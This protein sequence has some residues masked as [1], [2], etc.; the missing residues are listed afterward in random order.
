M[1]TPF[2]KPTFA[3][4][5]KPPS[6]PNEN[7]VNTQIKAKKIKELINLINQLQNLIKTLKSTIPNRKKTT[8]NKPNHTPTTTTK[9]MKHQL[10]KV[11]TDQLQKQR[12][13]IKNQ[14]KTPVWKL[15]QIQKYRANG[16]GLNIYN[17]G[18]NNK[19]HGIQNNIVK[20][21]K[22]QPNQIYNKTDHTH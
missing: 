18:Y 8:I 14:L 13:K 10:R 11:D 9:K 7:Q 5:I 12:K 2:I 6:N 20:S 1:G 16:N 15:K 21:R 17:P 22:S 4:I 3:K 19:T